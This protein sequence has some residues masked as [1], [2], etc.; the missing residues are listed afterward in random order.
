MKPR[1]G[2]YL[3]GDYWFRRDNLVERVMGF[4]PTTACLGSKNSTTELHPLCPYLVIVRNFV[5]Q[6]NAA[7]LSLAKNA[8]PV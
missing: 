7:I 8:R 1:K 6:H 4:E 3:H 5:I 2:F